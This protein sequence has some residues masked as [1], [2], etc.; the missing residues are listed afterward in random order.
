VP[1]RQGLFNTQPKLEQKPLLKLRLVETL[2][3]FKKARMNLMKPLSRMKV[4]HHASGTNIV[5]FV[6][7]AAT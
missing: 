6:R 5:L 2:A 7:M 4:V 1:L 3:K